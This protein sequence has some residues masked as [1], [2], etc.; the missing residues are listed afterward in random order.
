M[1]DTDIIRKALR[2]MHQRYVGVVY[3]W[4]SSDPPITPFV[5]A[6]MCEDAISALERVE[7]MAHAHYDIGNLPKYRDAVSNAALE[8]AAKRIEPKPG[9]EP[10]DFTRHRHTQYVRDLCASQIR[11]LKTKEPT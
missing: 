11:A 1:T 5:L 6:I 8:E 3:E 9:P 2:G 4:S 10:R 7:D